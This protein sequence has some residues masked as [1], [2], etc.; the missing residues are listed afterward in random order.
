MAA[1][2]TDHLKDIQDSLKNLPE[3][4]A[5]VLNRQG[6]GGAQRDSKG[7]FLNKDGAN[8]SEDKL[9]GKWQS[10]ERF[11]GAAG[12]FAPGLGQAGVMLRNIRE[13]GESWDQLQKSF[14]GKS[15]KMPQ[16]VSALDRRLNELKTD[17]L[18]S[19]PKP[20]SKANPD[21]IEKPVNAANSIDTSKGVFVGGQ[22]LGQ[23]AVDA[24]V[25]ALEKNTEALKENDPDPTEDS[26][27]KQT[28]SEE[29]ISRTSTEREERQGAT[30]PLRPPIRR[31]PGALRPERDVPQTGGGGV[32]I[33]G[34]ASGALA[35]SRFGP[36]GAAIGAVTGAF[37]G[38]H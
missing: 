11:L 24:L 27:E 7:R 6:A 28:K 13:L 30:S 35:G 21:K 5:I 32:S 31:I 23:A 22:R 38:G 3:R 37:G 29:P 19:I 4:L 26:E 14:G 15:G 16:P 12:K 1:T 18:P 20:V 10:S 36:W 25:R 33:K 9:P 2:P 8:A 34:A 17:S